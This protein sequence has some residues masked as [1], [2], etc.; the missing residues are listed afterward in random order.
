ML[1]VNHT[2][3]S[4][5]GALAIIA[6]THPEVTSNIG[7]NLVFVTSVASGATLG[8]VA[9]DM[10]IIIPS[11]LPRLLFYPLTRFLPEEK[12]SK[13]DYGHRTYSHS[14]IAIGLVALAT[15]LAALIYSNSI[16]YP[17]SVGFLLGYIF[18]ILADMT[19]VSGIPLLWCFKSKKYHI[20]PKFMRI[21]TGKSI[22]ERIYAGTF[23]FGA[24]LVFVLRSNLH[25]F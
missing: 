12:R 22:L 15:L 11:F 4:T 9:P 3:I 8:A 19:T 6:L 7:K 17:V 20:L 10:D 21:V 5:S 23:F 1:R 13:V 16:V 14:F 18:H 24:L 25:K 2:M